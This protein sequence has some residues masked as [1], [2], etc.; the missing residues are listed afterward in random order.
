M[1]M[2]FIVLE[3]GWK[4]KNNLICFFIDIISLGDDRYK[5]RCDI[6]WYDWDFVDDF[7]LVVIEVSGII[8]L[9]GVF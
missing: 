1:V 9:W 4:C 8:V 5:Y 7:I 6:F 3:F 2:V